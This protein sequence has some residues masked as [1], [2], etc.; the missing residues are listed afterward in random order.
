MPVQVP[1]RDGCLLCR[2][3]RISCGNQC[4][5]SFYIVLLYFAGKLIWE[6]FDDPLNPTEVFHGLPC[7]PVQ[8]IENYQ[9][10]QDDP[11]NFTDRQKFIASTSE[12]PQE[13]CPYGADADNG[14]EH[15]PPPSTASAKPTASTS[16]GTAPTPAAPADL[17]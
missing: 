13:S 6:A 3:H 9:L 14:G 1:Y 8:K 12:L 10:S 5:I 11:K 7:A 4:C 16:K 15:R 17:P 2:D